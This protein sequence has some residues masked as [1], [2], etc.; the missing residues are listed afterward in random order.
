MVSPALQRGE[1]GFHNFATESRRDGATTLFM[2]ESI[3]PELHLS[4]IS[5]VTRPFFRSQFSRAANTVKSTGLYWL[6]KN[7]LV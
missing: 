5:P 1:K 3:A 4:G 2:Q 7:S 6:R